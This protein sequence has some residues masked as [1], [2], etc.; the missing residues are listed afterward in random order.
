MPE[1]PFDYHT[2]RSCSFDTADL[3]LKS[4]EVEGNIVSVGF[5]SLRL[6]IDDNASASLVSTKTKARRHGLRSS[7]SFAI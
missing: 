3:L 6:E 1:V 4:A 2:H 5:V 7:Y